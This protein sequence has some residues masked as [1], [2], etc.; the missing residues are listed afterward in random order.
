[1]SGPLVRGGLAKPQNELGQCGSQHR[2]SIKVAIE[3]E[4]YERESAVVTTKW[5]K[6]HTSHCRFR[7]G[8]DSF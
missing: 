6:A 2:R 5:L 1:M 7:S 3:Y 4:R 8:F